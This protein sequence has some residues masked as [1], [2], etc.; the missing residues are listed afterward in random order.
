MKGNVDFKIREYVRRTML[1]ME[2]LPTRHCGMIGLNLKKICEELAK[3]DLY[4]SD[5]LMYDIYREMGRTIWGTDQTDLR[6]KIRHAFIAEVADE[7]RSPDMGWLSDLFL[8]KDKEEL[9]YWVDIM[10]KKFSQNGC[11]K[12]LARSTLR[13]L[14][15]KP[16]YRRET[17]L[18]EIYADAIWEIKGRFTFEEMLKRLRE[19]GLYNV[20]YA[21]S[22]FIEILDDGYTKASMKH[23]HVLDCCIQDECKFYFRRAISDYDRGALGKK[24]SK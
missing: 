6:A 7:A 20:G 16:P 19:R 3:V 9:E 21:L 5:K 4:L 13:Q 23:R 14:K 17:L 24:R 15:L 2:D 18:R 1:A 11:T 22:L 12:E 10:Q 8:E